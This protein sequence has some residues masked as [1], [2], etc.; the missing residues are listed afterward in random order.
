MTPPPRPDMMTYEGCVGAKASIFSGK[1]AVETFVHELYKVL[2][3]RK[4]GME[5]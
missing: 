4:L 1:R 3:G 5:S 2:T